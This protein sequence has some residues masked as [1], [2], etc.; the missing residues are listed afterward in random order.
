VDHYDPK[1]RRWSYESSGHLGDWS[2]PLIFLGLVGTV[3][4]ILVAAVYFIIHLF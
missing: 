4:A 2:F 3:V 1:T